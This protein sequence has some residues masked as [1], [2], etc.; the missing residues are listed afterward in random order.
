MYKSQLPS[1]PFLVL[2]PS[3]P[4]PY[5]LLLPSKYKASLGKSAKSV[6]SPR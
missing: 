4:T 2:P 6:P 5:P 1:P 3:F